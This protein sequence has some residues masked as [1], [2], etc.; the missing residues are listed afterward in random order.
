MKTAISNKQEDE[1][2]LEVCLMPD[3]QLPSQACN[4]HLLSWIY[5]ASRTKTFNIIDGLQ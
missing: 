1:K 4:F 3:V 5:G 2:E